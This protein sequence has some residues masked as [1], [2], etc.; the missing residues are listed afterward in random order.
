M[1][2]PPAPEINVMAIAT[3]NEPTTRSTV[4]FVATAALKS[5]GSMPIIGMPWIVGQPRPDPM[6]NKN[7][8]G[9]HTWSRSGVSPL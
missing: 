4:W 5:F 6:P 2:A 7:A 9:N 1:V 8:A 3:P